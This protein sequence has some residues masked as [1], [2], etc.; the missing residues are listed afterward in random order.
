M[1]IICVKGI[2]LNTISFKENSK[3]LNVLTKEHGL[4]GVMSKGCKK[5]NSKLRILSEKFAYANFNIYYK[6]N[7][8]S[9]LVDGTIINYFEN[10]KSDI[11]KLGYMSYLSELTMGVYKESESKD[12]YDLFINAISKIEEG[13]DVKIISN[14]LELQYLEYLGIN[15]CLDGCVMCGST[16]IS[17]ISLSKGG[18]V[19]SN[20]KTNEIVYD[21]KITKLFRLYNYVDISKISNLDI[22]KN[23]SDKIN[24]IIDEYYDTYSGI[25]PKSKKFLKDLEKLD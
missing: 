14:I 20:C 7:S 22:D 19:C 21:S 11:Y 15:L 2:V 17:T 12:I 5:L 23:V 13:L 10:I 4:I 6:E 25:H 9:T 8:L 18:Y 1:E 24:D 3:I 16:K